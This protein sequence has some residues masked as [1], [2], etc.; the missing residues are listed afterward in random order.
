M[1]AT[2]KESPKNKDSLRN[3]GNKNKLGHK[4]ATTFDKKFH[5]NHTAIKYKKMCTRKYTKIRVQIYVIIFT[6]TSLVIVTG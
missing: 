2:F 3:S 4:D 6:C 1:E 5:R